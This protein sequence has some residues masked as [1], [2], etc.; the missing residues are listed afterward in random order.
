MFDPKGLSV[1]VGRIVVGALALGVSLSLTACG[2]GVGSNNTGANTNPS[3]VDLASVGLT[4]TGKAL[5][6]S[7][8]TTKNAYQLYGTAFALATK[9]I[10]DRV[11]AELGGASGTSNLGGLV[12]HD[13]RYC[14]R[15][16]G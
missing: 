14:A 10:I 16:S 8:D 9:H 13:S 3:S 12:H 4:A 6:C 7:T 1:R 11:L 15:E 5:K 2:S